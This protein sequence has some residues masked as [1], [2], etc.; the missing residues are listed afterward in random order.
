M[1]RNSDTYPTAPVIICGAHGGGTSY[2]T[3]MLRYAGF[4]A[5]GDSGAISQRKFH[6][7]VSKKRINRELGELFGDGDILSSEAIV[8]VERE[9]ACNLKHW[10]AKARDQKDSFDE[11]FKPSNV[12]V[13]R[14]SL[15]L[16]RLANKL[17]PN[18]RR[19]WPGYLCWK[20]GA[21]PASAPWGW[22]DPRNS[23]TLPLWLALYPQARVLVIQKGVVQN[24]P[25]SSSGAWFRSAENSDQVER[26]QAPKI[27]LPPERVI[28]VQFEEVTSSSAAL[29]ELLHWL[30]MPVLSERQFQG[31]LQVTEFEST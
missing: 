4:N 30:G 18:E 29:N 16:A 8:G 3:K 25:R 23:I 26:Y 2:V 24:T 21:W 14:A 17:R 7:S 11:A 9:L 31:L 1:V 22:K 6:E 28:Q 5:G 19:T 12:A 10:V 27:P 15:K 20:Y 13:L